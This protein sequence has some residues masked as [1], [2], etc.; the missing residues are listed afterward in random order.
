MSLD[1]IFEPA[2]EGYPAIGN[3]RP[4]LSETYFSQP[5][6]RGS[7]YA[8]GFLHPSEK[9]EADT[10]TPQLSGTPRTEVSTH[11]ESGISSS[12]GSVPS[13]GVMAEESSNSISGA[14]LKR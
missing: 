4:R 7:H 1:G 5:S 8:N 6:T 3:I 13:P 10:V 9:N 11:P 2:L 14:D 12:G